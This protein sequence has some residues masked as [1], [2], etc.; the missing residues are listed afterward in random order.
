MTNDE[1]S[2]QVR[3]REYKMKKAAVFKIVVFCGAILAGAVFS[4]LIPLRETFSEKEKRELTAFPE[5]TWESFMGGSY[6]GQ[7]DT[8]FADT[9][10]FRDSL[11]ACNEKVNNLY[12]IRNQVIQGTLVAGD[13]IPDVAGDMESHLIA[14]KDAGGGQAPDDVEITEDITSSY[15]SE[16]GVIYSN[17]ETNYGFNQLETEIEA[18]DIGTD[19]EYTEGEIAATAGE[20]L[21][22]IFV[23]GD[24]AYNYYSFSQVNS[25]R[26]TDVVNNLAEALSGMS[27]VYSMIVPTSIDITLDA[28]TRNSLTSSNQKKAIL[29]MYSRMS[30]DVGK[31]YVY[32]VLHQH[33]DEYIYFR[34]D[35][36]WTALGAYYAYNV[37]IWQEGKTANS[38]DSYEKMMF[39]D[40]K[41]SFYRQSG[42]T[43]L[44]NN[45]DTVEAYKPVGTNRM[46]MI[47]NRD[48]HIDYNVITDVSGWSST[49]K[50]STFIGGD[51][52]FVHINNPEIN[53]ESSILVVKESFGN[54]FVPFLVDHYKNVYVVDYRYFNGTV[55]ELVDRYN[56]GTVL[57]LNNIAATSTDSRV[58]EMENVCR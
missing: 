10:P 37:F 19:V 24:R 32:D 39:S 17:I 46:E 48:E 31:C 22:S 55:S 53:Q 2:K 45:P 34:T 4:M 8:W 49:S 29:Y 30:K 41:G 20:S 11:I 50:Y 43:S 15:Y 54:A 35:H 52:K 26:Y 3:L 56:I 58:S 40:F 1:L 27:K 38:L 47:N 13:E 16:D 18:S 25:D 36:H 28:A 9:F 23:V 21:G 51:N 42:V 12:G 6:F 14:S 44:G 33:R 7:I 5:F 57:M